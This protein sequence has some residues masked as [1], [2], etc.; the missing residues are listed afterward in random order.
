MTPEKLAF[1]GTSDLAGLLRGKSIPESALADR[2]ARGVGIT[3]SNLMLSPFGPI[4]DTPF[5]TA[6]D[7]MLVPDPSTQRSI[8]VIAGPDIELL[9]GDFRTNDVTRREFLGIIGNPASR[10]DR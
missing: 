1:I 5:G 3:H 4:L 9:L 7:L 2:M 6:G 8:P 10:E